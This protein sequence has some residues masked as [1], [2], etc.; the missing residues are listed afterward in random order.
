ME[1]LGK[2]G[3]EKIQVR[4]LPASRMFDYYLQR[5]KMPISVLN[6]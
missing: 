5:R 4:E 1:M 3:L 6:L 2:V